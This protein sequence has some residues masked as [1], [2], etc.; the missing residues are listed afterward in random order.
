M[1]EYKVSDHLKEKIKIPHFKK[2]Y[3]CEAQKFAIIEKI[4]AF[5]IKNR[6]SQTQLAKKVGV[7]QQQISK[8]EHGEFSSVIILEKILLAIGMTV[9]IKAVP[10]RTSNKN[11]SASR[12]AKK[13][14]QA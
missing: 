13:R 6:M 9:Q 4:V 7:T 14:I 2:L 5:R 10:I 3:E 12:L 8:V 11:R 1:K